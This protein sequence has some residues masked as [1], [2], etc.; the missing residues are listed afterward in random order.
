[1][2][3]IIQYFL[4]RYKHKFQIC[5]VVG[6][7]FTVAGIIDASLFS[8]TEFYRKHQMGKLSWFLDKSHFFPILSFL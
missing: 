8:L 7:T 1:M 2:Y 3:C 6:G 5:A 4:I